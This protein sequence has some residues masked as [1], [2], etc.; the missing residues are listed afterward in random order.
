MTISGIPRDDLPNSQAERHA[1]LRDYFCDIDA[2]ATLTYAGWN[3]NLHWPDGT[4]RHVDPRLAEGLSWWG[5][6]IT[7]PTMVHARRRRGR[8]LSALYDTWTLHSWSDFL[9]RE[10]ISRDERLVVL[11]VDDHRDLGSPR[12]FESGGAWLDSITRHSCDLDQPDTVL[13]AIE[14]GAIGMGSFM[15]P[16]LHCF[17]GTEVRHLC[18]PP[19]AGSTKDFAIELSSLRDTLLDPAH[20]RPA[21][22]LSEYKSGGTLARY[23]LTSSLVDWL[24][25]LGGRRV[26]LHIDMDY[27]NNRYDGDSDWEHRAVPLDPPVSQILAKIDDVTGALASAVSPDKLVDVVVAYSPGFFPAEFWATATQ[28]LIPRLERIYER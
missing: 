27:F 22:T 6:G 9:H 5:D 2:E 14:S 10:Q 21:I 1:A 20:T 19:K 18:Q 24:E 23:R 28:R 13:A 17:P 12:L 25:E 7:L 16:F 15:T 26:L 11:H 3:I 4:D 8:I